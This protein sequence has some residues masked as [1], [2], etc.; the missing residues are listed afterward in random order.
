MNP[1]EMNP[2]EMNPTEMNPIEMNPM[3]EDIP[4]PESATEKKRPVGRPPGASGKYSCG[5]CGEDGHNTKTCPNASKQDMNGSDNTQDREETP[6]EK[7]AMTLV[8]NMTLK[9]KNTALELECD[10]WRRYGS[11]DTFI[12]TILD[13]ENTMRYIGKSFAMKARVAAHTSAEGKIAKLHDEQVK[14]GITTGTPRLVVVMAKHFINKDNV[15]DESDRWANFNEAYAMKRFNQNI[16]N[17]LSYNKNRSVAS[18]AFPTDYKN[19]IDHGIS[20]PMFAE[21]MRAEFK[22]TDDVNNG[23][24]NVISKP[25]DKDDDNNG[26]DNVI[27]NPT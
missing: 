22:Y 26:I 13:C 1:T 4:E 15:K 3:E 9:A 8:E 16:E 21:A 25:K 14:K 2:T 27:S 10:E 17:P 20:S 7:Q 5:N 11:V 24:Y 18:V 23:I 19:F 6:T 12:Y